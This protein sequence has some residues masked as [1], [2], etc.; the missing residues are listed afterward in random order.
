VEARTSGITPL[1]EVLLDD[2][3]PRDTYRVAKKLPRWPSGYR[4]K[5]FVASTSLRSS[6][7]ELPWEPD[8]AKR[9][10]DRQAPQGAPPASRAGVACKLPWARRIRQVPRSAEV[11]RV[12]HGVT[13]DCGFDREI[14]A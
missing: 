9:E 2:T 3:P 8:R 1:I 10:V 5:D 4:V 13:S 12:P 7:L 6:G 14:T 11:L